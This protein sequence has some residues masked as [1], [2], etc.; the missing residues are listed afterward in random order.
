MGLIVNLHHQNVMKTCTGANNFPLL[1]AYGHLGNLYNK[2]SH[3]KPRAY[4]CSK[5]FFGRLIFGGAYILS[6]L[7]LEG[8]F[9]FKM[10]WASQV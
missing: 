1:N 2:N 10:G 5:S 8:I 9:H 3:N 6:G 4:I 7:L